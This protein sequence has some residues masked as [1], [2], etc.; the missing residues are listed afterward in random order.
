MQ[1]S[2]NEEQTN[3]LALDGRLSLQDAVSRFYVLRATDVLR[4]EIFQR[5]QDLEVEPMAPE[6]CHLLLFI[7]HRWETTDHPDPTGKQL[8]ALKSLIHFVCDACDALSESSIEERLRILPTL[9]QYGALQAILLVSRLSSSVLSIA[10]SMASQRVH[11]WLPNHIGIWY[12]FACLPQKP[13]SNSEHEEVQAALLALPDLL[14][15]EEISLIALRDADDDYESRGWCIAEARLSSDKMVF[16]PLVLRLDRLGTMSD[17][18]PLVSSDTNDRPASQFRAALT[19][20]EDKT[21]AAM[22]PQTC[23]KIIVL[24]ACTNPDSIPL[25]ADDS[26]MLGLSKIA[27]FSLT[28]IILL[29]TDLARKEGQVVNFSEAILRLL[30]EKGLQ[31][32]DDD[33]LIYVGLLAFLWSCEKRTRLAELFR[34]CLRRHIKK[35]SLLMRVSVMESPERLDPKAN[36]RFN[37]SLFSI[38]F[39]FRLFAWL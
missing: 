35:E 16:T 33:D 28:W 5:R 2:N 25:P 19:A 11:E 14:L 38:A 24:Q 27:Q 18:I 22:D 15:S 29:L 8:A 36:A 30:K 23:W 6:N 13:R 26:P 20:W 39:S 12:D 1:I 32:S 9:R 10:S 31:C 37:I 4:M 21:E 7:S 17:Q 3:N 34:Q